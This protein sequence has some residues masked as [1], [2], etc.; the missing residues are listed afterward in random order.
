M[1][2]TVS[3]WLTKKTEKQFNDNESER[4]K[5]DAVPYVRNRTLIHGCGTSSDMYMLKS[6]SSVDV[7]AG[8]S[9]A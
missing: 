1:L 9:A 3:I 2:I 4:M 8:D 5:N 7:K 6:F